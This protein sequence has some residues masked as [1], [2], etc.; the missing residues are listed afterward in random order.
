MRSNL[1]AEIEETAMKFLDAFG[2]QAISMIDTRDPDI[3]ESI[4]DSLD[5]DFSNVK[6]IEVIEFFK[7]VRKRI[8]ALASSPRR[9]AFGESVGNEY[10]KRPSEAVRRAA[11][12]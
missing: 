10:I 6:P 11:R 12:R 3:W 7:A 5:I 8:A 2:D 4:R 1:S 9:F